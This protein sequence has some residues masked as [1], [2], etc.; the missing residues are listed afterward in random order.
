[1]DAKLSKEVESALADSR[2]RQRL[3]KLLAE[4]GYGETVQIKGR[5]YRL[6]RFNMNEALSSSGSVATHNGDTQ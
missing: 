4:G 3:G 6:K 5:K 1:M 2:S